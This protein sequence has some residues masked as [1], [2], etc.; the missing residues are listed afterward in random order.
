MQHIDSMVLVV[1]GKFNSGQFFGRD[2]Q[3]GRMTNGNFTHTKFLKRE[4]FEWLGK[5]GSLF[6]KGLPKRSK[7]NL[8]GTYAITI[9]LNYRLDFLSLRDIR[10]KRNVISPWHNERLREKWVDGV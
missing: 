4:K 6:K 9:P 7:L 1:V 8:C 2:F 5:L 3:G 10:K